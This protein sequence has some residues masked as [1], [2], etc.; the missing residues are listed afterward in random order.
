MEGQSAYSDTSWLASYIPFSV[1]VIILSG[2]IPLSK[3]DVSVDGHM[4]SIISCLVLCQRY[5]TRG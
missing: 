1:E 2:D 3:T 5:V 4:E